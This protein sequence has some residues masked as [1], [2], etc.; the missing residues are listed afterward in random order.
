MRRLL[1]PW[2]W[3]LSIG[4][5]VILL[6]LLAA[7]AARYYPTGELSPDHELDD[8]VLWLLVMPAVD[9]VPDVAAEP[10]PEDENDEEEPPPEPELD[11]FKNL[12]D[13]WIAGRALEVWDGPAPADSIVVIELP[14]LAWDELLQAG[15]DTT[16]A[17]ILAR[18]QLMW[19]QRT[20]V[21]K[22]WG[23]MDFYDKRAARFQASKKSVFNEGWLEA[24]HLR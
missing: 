5:A 20:A 21:M 19:E 17:G 11:A 13:G 8:D 23:L 2:R 9:V 4:A 12:W 10:D 1:H 3:P 14:R 7:G 22:A 15:A 24:E 16:S 6:L 18:S